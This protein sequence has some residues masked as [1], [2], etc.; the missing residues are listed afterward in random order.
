VGCFI[1]RT[2][3]I[4]GLAGV[5]VALT[6]G[7]CATA[8]QAT[9]SSS[10]AGRYSLASPP[11]AS[12]SSAA[13]TPDVTS[14]SQPAAAATSPVETA[15]HDAAIREQAAMELGSDVAASMP[16][17]P[18][19]PPVEPV[20]PGAAMIVRSIAQ[21]LADRRSAGDAV[22][23]DLTTLQNLS[24]SGSEEFTAFVARLAALLN[25]AGVEHRI[26]F[27][28]DKS[29]VCEYRMLG[30][31]YL[32]NASGFDQWEMYMSLSPADRDWQVWDARNAVRIL[33][34]ARAGQPQIISIGK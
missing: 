22:T 16:Q 26:R 15:S 1:L 27:V 25:R 6:M 3:R 21:T 29:T 20:D 12:D 30:T 2:R 24:R 5:S 14:R 10:N 13:T 31:A 18:E 28:D 17:V 33:R 11:P 9:G 34:T 8:P 7:G 19:T 4:S 23:I 32:V